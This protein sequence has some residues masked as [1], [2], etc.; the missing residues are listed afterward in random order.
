M[1]TLLFLSL[2]AIFL[3]TSLWFAEN[4]GSIVIEWM[5]YNI[6]TSVA[7]AV[8]FFITT[9]IIC[10]LFL[11]VILWIKSAPGR[12]KK[13]LKERRLN[14][15]LMALTQ[16]FA[17]IAAGDT[18]QALTLAKKA[19]HN[20]N[21]I[22]ITKLLSAQTAQL[23]GNRELAKV[24]YTSMLDDKETEIIAIKGLLIE[25]KQ[26]NDLPK[27]LFLAEKAY[28]LKPNT[29]WVILILIDLY[30]KLGKWNKAEEIT[31]KALKYKLIS[32]DAATR[33]LGLFAFAEYEEKLILENNSSNDH[34]IKKAYKLVPDLIPISTAYAKMLTRT[35]KTRKAVKIL[36][37]QWRVTPHPYIAA[38]YMDIYAPET[39]EI[40]L[41]KAERLFQLSGEHQEG[42]AI[43]ASVA[44]D[45]GQT[46]I[47]RKHLMA[48][49]SYGETRSICLMMADL[50]TIEKANYSSVHHWRERAIFANN[51][52]IWVCTN[53]GTKLYKWHINCDK[54]NAF[55][56]MEWKS[57]D[58]PA[59]TNLLK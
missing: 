12:Y 32:N 47:A 7:V 2:L 20:L 17:A 27:A 49:L 14:N 31:K 34:L 46:G 22:P 4:D 53:C 6:Q 13:A 42:H 11:Q 33:S 38:A 21:N 36:E 57:I 44:L 1:R 26:D 40:R 48:A 28:G 50:E 23:E 19:S 30:K 8:L 15:G 43:F 18:K 59:N 52:A 10:T 3:L 16:G 29:D 9:L 58:K 35:G 25:A 56:S 41:E 39:H 45:A 24:H 37:N 51:L 5:G 55:D 54:C